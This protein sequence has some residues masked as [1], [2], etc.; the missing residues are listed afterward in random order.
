MSDEQSGL[1]ERVNTLPMHVDSPT[2]SKVVE[3]INSEVLAVLDRL[4][5][6]AN[7]GISVFERA[8]SVDSA[9]E[10][11]KERYS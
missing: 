10:A 8:A 4:E 1:R 9:I 11:E 5:D 3:L 2:I 7:D 6:A